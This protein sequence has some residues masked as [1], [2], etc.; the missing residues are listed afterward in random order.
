MIPL[1]RQAEVSQTVAELS[2]R[3]NYYRFRTD[4]NW[5]VCTNYQLSLDS[6]ALGEEACVEIILRAMEG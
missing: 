6:G 2:C 1:R 3:R 5:G 4:R